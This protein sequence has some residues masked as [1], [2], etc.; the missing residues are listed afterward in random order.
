M[1]SPIIIKAAKGIAAALMDY[2]RVVTEGLCDDWDKKLGVDDYRH[3][4]RDKYPGF[5]S[6]FMQFVKEL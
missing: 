1:K 3:A 5:D 4:G 2:L 6:W